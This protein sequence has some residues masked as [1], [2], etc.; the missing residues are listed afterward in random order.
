MILR[1]WEGERVER[2]HTR[3]TEGGERE[4]TYYTV[5]IYLA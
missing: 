4:T 2:A 3:E 5:I 1:E